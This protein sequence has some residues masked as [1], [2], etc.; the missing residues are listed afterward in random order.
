MSTLKT[1]LQLPNST[2]SPLIPPN[3][4][5][6]KARKSRWNLLRAAQQNQAETERAVASGANRF[7]G[8]PVS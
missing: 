8:A 2:C 4:I 5:Y 3:R 6:A 1:S 7:D